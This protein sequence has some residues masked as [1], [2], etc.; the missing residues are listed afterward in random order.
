MSED[1]RVTHPTHPEVCL[2]AEQMSDIDAGRLYDAA[3]RLQNGDES[4]F[5]DIYAETL[6]AF[7]EAV[8][9]EC[10]DDPV[11]Q[12]VL[13]TAYIRIERELSHPA[14]AKEKD[15]ANEV[16]EENPAA[17][18]NLS[19]A[20]E[21]GAAE[22]PDAVK[23]VKAAENPAAAEESEYLA[24]AG[25]PELSGME[26]EGLV[27]WMV[28]VLQDVLNR[29]LDQK[30]R[31]VPE[32]LEEFLKIGKSIISSKDIKDFEKKKKAEE[33]KKEEEEIMNLH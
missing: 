17:A 22:N 18:G 23:E 13:Q 5:N 21:A 11:Y 33:D 31:E 30:E 26:P 3:V 29:T 8:K 19:A 28:S 6:Q 4:A 32:D 15:T 25:R 9:G 10:Q 2:D 14:A 12:D 1:K 24:A 16:R 7:S 20:E 27:K